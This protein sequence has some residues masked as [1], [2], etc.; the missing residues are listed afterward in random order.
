MLRRRFVTF[1]CSSIAASTVGHSLG[2]AATLERKW[3]SRGS[4]STI[5]N[6]NKDI[7]L[8][9]PELIGNGN[10][11]PIT[12]LAPGADLVSLFAEENPVPDVATFKFGPLNPSG[13]VT[14][15]IRLAK[16]QK[17]LALAQLKDGTLVGAYAEVKVTIGGCGG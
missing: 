9:A 17:I 15:R 10:T 8:I 2:F 11:V 14:T 7:V 12:I 6:Y 16:S 13:K 5:Q 1:A 3:F 4:I